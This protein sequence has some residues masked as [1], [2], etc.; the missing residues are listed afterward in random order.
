ME[1]KVKDIEKE[2]ENVELEDDDDYENITTD[3]RIVEIEKKVNIILILV[4]ISIIISF[5]SL[6]STL[7]KGDS[8]TSNT[9]NQAQEGTSS[10]DTSSFKEIKAADIASE[11]KNETIVVWIGRQT[12]GYCAAYAPE[13][14]EAAENYGIQARYIDIAKIVDFVTNPQQPTITDR[15]AW[16]TITSLSGSGEWA[17][18][19]KENM[20]NTPLTLI[21]KNNKVVGGLD[22]Y[23]TAENVEEAFADAGL[24]K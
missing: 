11:S 15:D 4:I 16:E 24:K 20:G 17:T 6:V 18:F 1:K 10:Y 23:T 8:E 13:I 14:A 3:E 12:C 19:A 2:V 5:I 9:N 21:I 7:N 22:V